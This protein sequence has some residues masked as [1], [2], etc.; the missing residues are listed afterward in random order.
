MDDDLTTISHIIDN[1]DPNTMKMID[2][3]N[4]KRKYVNRAV[5]TS[6]TNIFQGSASTSL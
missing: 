2:K 4:V 1:I 6:G 5:K 3:N